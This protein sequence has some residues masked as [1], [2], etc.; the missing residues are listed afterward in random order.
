MND[1]PYSPRRR[2]ALVLTGTGTA[3]AYHAGVLHALHE[4]GVKIDLVAGRGIGAVGALFAAIDGGSRLWGPDG[5]WRGAGAPRFYRFRAPLRV[6]AWALGAGLVA[7]LSPLVL[8]ALAVLVYI[9]GLVAALVGLT[10]AGAAATA[11]FG[12][13]LDRLFAPLALPT[14]MPRLVAFALVVALAAVAVGAVG[15]RRGAGRRR[16]RGAAWWRLAG[17]PLDARGAISGFRGL[18]WQL[19][20]G[21]ASLP[22]PPPGEIGRRYA[23][24]VLENLGQPG[25]REVLV[26]VHDLDART[27]VV[28][29]LLGDGHRQRFFSGESRVHAAARTA[30]AFDLAGAASDHVADALAAALSLPA[31]TEPHL[32]VFRPESYWRGESHRMCDRPDAVARLVAEVAAA[33]AE[34]IVL[35]T[36]A[37]GPGGPHALAAGRRELKARAGEYVRGAETAA[38]ADAL[39]ARA[40]R[41]GSVFVVRPTHNPVGPFDFGGADDD[42]S[43]RRHSL[44][45]LAD[46]GY[47]DAYRQFIEPVVGASGDRL[48]LAGRSAPSMSSSDP[49]DRIR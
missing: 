47:E 1:S 30:E 41:G 33:G 36:D 2:T 20:R 4:A 23:E 38:V 8:L 32:V 24:L 25:F 14:V 48:E 9:A 16:G 43:D 15:W 12:A 35:V 5:P 28:F 11:W 42:R 10:S 13:V 26:T 40:G 31:V 6:A 19:I 45:E 39:D 46:R 3:G 37:P 7:L 18:L 17:A 34:Q 44:A 29:A 49:A 22:E 27:D 21:A